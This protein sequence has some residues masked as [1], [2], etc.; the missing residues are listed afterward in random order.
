M[1]FHDVKDNF[2][3]GVTDRLGGPFA[4]V[5]ECTGAAFGIDSAWQLAGY[6]GKVLV[7]G[8]YMEHKASFVWTEWLHKE[9]EIIASV[10]S[11]GAGP[12]RCVSRRAARYHW[13]SW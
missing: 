7:L 13:A 6:E 11:A 8:E 10:A 5:I 4:N 9:Q 12:R 2:V 1:D 3:K